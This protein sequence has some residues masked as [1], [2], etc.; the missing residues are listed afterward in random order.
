MGRSLE[1][2]QMKYFG[3]FKFSVSVDEHFASDAWIPL[4]MYT[5]YDGN[6]Q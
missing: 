5:A 1:Y 6:V 2:P 3:K 4:F